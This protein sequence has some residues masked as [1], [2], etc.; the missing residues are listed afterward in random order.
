M[1]TLSPSQI[2][3]LLLNGGFS[4]QQAS[5]MTAIAQ[6]ESGRNVSA[7]GDVA[8]QDAKWGPSVGLFQIRTLKA[9][10]GTGSDRD[11]Q[12]L[13]NNPA[14]QV[15]AALRISN[16]GRSFSPWSTYTNGAYRQYVSTPLQAGVAVDPGIYAG[17][18]AY[19]AGGNGGGAY[20]AG[21]YGAGAYG[22][23]AG[24]DPFQIDQG[25]RPSMVT[26]QDGDGLTDQFEALLGTDPTK[27]DTDGDGLSDAYESSV[28]H[29]DPLSADTDHD[30]LT[31]N[32]EVARGSDAGHSA[33]PAAARA[34][35]FGGMATMD[36]DGDGLSDAYEQRLRLNPLVADT[37]RDGLADGAELAR[38]TNPLSMDSNQDG[39][40]DGFAAEHDLLAID[41]QP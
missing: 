13:M 1:S 22:G 35:G 36:S 16:N 39:L 14:A 25:L 8:L 31:D 10:T 30:G 32:D 26:D 15:Q 29:T 7:V 6:A 21:A 9:E 12:H 18:G 41:P 11:I 27:S 38:G 24:A 19:G 17:G 33:I 20:G 37:D 5:L 4:A 28:S 34:A 2:Y 40:A 23:Q 3:T